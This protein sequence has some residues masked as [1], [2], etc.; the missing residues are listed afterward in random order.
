MNANMPF[1]GAEIENRAIKYQNKRKK[2]ENDQ[3]INHS[4]NQ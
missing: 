3:V 1:D 2:R 4:L